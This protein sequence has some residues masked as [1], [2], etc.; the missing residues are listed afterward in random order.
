MRADAVTTFSTERLRAERLTSAHAEYLAALDRDPDV[1]A[2]LGG[3]RTPEESAEWLARNLAHWDDN[4]FGPWM[5]RDATTGQLVG[6]VA[7]RWIDPSVGEEIVEVGYAL[8]RSAWGA[9]L[10]TEAARGVITVAR[11]RYGMAQLGAITLDHNR[12]SIR[13]IEKCGFRFERLVDHPAGVH[14]FFRLVL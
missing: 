7:L 14:R 10:A 12:A 8:Q 2:W 13:V 1:T 5:L 9:G 6:R 11:D 3:L 4:G